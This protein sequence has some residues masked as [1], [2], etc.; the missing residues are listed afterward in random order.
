MVWPYPENGR[1]KIAKTSSD[2]VSYGKEEEKRQAKNYSDE[3]SD[4]RNRNLRKRIGE[5]ES[6]DNR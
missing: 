6:R 3:C 2:I 4:E 1:G 5:A